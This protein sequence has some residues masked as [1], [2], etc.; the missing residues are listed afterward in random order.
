[1]PVEDGKFERDLERLQNKEK[2]F[3]EM[4]GFSTYEEFRKWVSN[5][6]LGPDGEII[7]KFNNES[8]RENIIRDI[9]QDAES[10]KNL[11]KTKITLSVDSAEA[12]KKLK[13]VTKALSEVRGASSKVRLNKKG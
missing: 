4:F 2:S 10:H 6:L 11:S 1:M 9:V 13:E 8:V 12:N 5:C 7:A 3:Y